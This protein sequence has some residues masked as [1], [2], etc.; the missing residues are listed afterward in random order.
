MKW[1]VIVLSALSVG[2]VPKPRAYTPSLDTPELTCKELR[3][4]KPVHRSI[5]RRRLFVRLT[6]G[7]RRGQVVNH[8]VPLACGGCD[9]PSNMEWMSV[10]EWKGRTGPE[11]TDCGRHQGG[12][13]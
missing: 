9:V 8:I 12:E 10:A 11:R 5:N 6:G 13:W 2:A 4:G 7:E 1:L 3:D